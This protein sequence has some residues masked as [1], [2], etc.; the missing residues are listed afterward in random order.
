MTVNAVM[1]QQGVLLAGNKTTMPGLLKMAES[2]SEFIGKKQRILPKNKMAT[3]I[4]HLS[5][6]KCKVLF[7]QSW[8]TIS[9]EGFHILEG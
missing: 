8:I 9:Q 3:L 1:A 7:S 5:N 6:V 2:S 4:N